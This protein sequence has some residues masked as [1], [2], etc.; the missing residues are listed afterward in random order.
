MALYDR[1]SYSRV[2]DQRWHKA[3]ETQPLTSYGPS[4]HTLPPSLLPAPPPDAR[5]SRSRFGSFGSDDKRYVTQT[6]PCARRTTVTHR[7]AR[8]RQR[9]GRT[10]QPLHASQSPSAR[11]C[12]RRLEGECT[13]ARSLSVLVLW[14]SP[15]YPKKFCARRCYFVPRFVPLFR[16]SVVREEY[17]VQTWIAFGAT[18]LPGFF[19]ISDSE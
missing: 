18:V 2:M 11:Q 5:V 6:D 7:D 17:D 15:R 1:T 4:P 9:G 19:T 16:M 13:Y 8:P 3:I 10:R 14:R 12:C